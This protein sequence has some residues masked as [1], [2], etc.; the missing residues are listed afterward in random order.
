MSTRRM[1]LRRFLRAGD[2]ISAGLRPIG[3]FFKKWYEEL[4]FTAFMVCLIGGIGVGALEDED[5]DYIYGGSSI[6]DYHRSLVDEDE[7][8]FVMGRKKTKTKQYSVSS[9]LPKV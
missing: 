2:A 9:N 5:E 8:V 4:F 1:W 3:A 7:D 6:S